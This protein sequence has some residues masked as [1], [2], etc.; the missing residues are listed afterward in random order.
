M[1]E[2]TGVTKRFEGKKQVTALNT[3]N[4]RI[5][6]GEMVSLVGPSG[7]GKSTLLNLIGG[8]DKPST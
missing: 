8:L 1:I 7:S 4:L 2:L 3:V 6:K 5:D